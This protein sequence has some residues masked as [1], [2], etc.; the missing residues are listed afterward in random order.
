[1]SPV[2]FRCD[3]NAFFFRA[4][5]QKFYLNVFSRFSYPVFSNR[6]GELLNIRIL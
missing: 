1:M 2:V 5:S 6:Y 3:N 4:V